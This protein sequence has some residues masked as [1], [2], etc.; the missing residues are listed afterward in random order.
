ML[1]SSQEAGARSS[2]RF[3]RWA[4]VAW[5]TVELISTIATHQPVVGQYELHALHGASSEFAR[6]D[7]FI[8]QTKSYHPIQSWV[9]SEAAARQRLT[10]ASYGFAALGQIAIVAA[11]LV[12]IRSLGAPFIMAAPA[13]FLLNYGIQDTWGSQSLSGP[14]HGLA[15]VS[16]SLLVTGRRRAGLIVAVAALYGHF[17]VGAWLLA[18]AML[19][20]L[21]DL[22]Q[23]EIDHRES[24][25]LIALAVVP[26]LPM[27]VWAG[28]N[29]GSGVPPETYDLLFHIRAPHHYSLLFFSNV[30][31]IK[32]AYVALV[33]LGAEWVLRP[34]GRRIRT[35]I[36]ALVGIQVLGYVFLEVV[37]WPLYVRLF[38]YRV[39]PWL[40][41]L[42]IVLVVA[43]VAHPSVRRSQRALG[44]IA[45]F[46]IFAFDRPGIL[47][48]VVGSPLAIGLALL[49][50][51]L[52]IASVLLARPVWVDRAL[53]EFPSR[54]QAMSALLLVSISLN[55]YLLARELPTEIPLVLPTRLYEHD[56]NFTD[57][58]EVGS[59][60]LVGPQHSYMRQL[61]GRAIVV[62]FANFP[63]GGKEILEW[64][65]RLEA[66]VGEKLPH[67]R[68]RGDSLE[69]Q[70]GDLFDQRPFDE[71]VG[72]ARYFEADA[73]VVT[74]DSRIADEIRQRQQ[75]Y[76]V[77]DDEWIAVMIKDA[78]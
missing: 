60:L 76:I 17:S 48:R 63:M 22:A 4:A 6:G 70:L 74:S 57:A 33:A 53:S 69:R 34:L 42:A 71:L 37:R 46:G 30:E 28:S 16:L 12:L 7:W 27:I 8:E 68:S 77:I 61:S 73:L 78:P 19:L 29:F 21:H 51:F 20:V 65:E 41:F 31:H 58:F 64:Q 50:G 59:L 2:H 40:T 35:L 9:S 54:R 67:R 10:E 14:W 24:V 62:D 49:L 75:P 15:V 39:A 45:A 32:A 26:A 25:R 13:L 47:D 44:L 43:L 52:A 56:N 66:V 36:L 5:I 38:P 55:G 23:G 1:L 18:V 3:A 72:V 11:L